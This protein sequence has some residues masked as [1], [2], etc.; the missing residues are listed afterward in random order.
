VVSS[1]EISEM[2]ASRREGKQKEKNNPAQEIVTAKNT[3]K[4]CPECGKDN[5]EDAKFCVGCG[6]SFEEK[7]IEI[8]PEDIKNESDT[9]ICSSCGSEIP[10][11]AKFCVVCGETQSDTKEEPVE[12]ILETPEEPLIKSEKI[13]TPS[14]FEEPIKLII[15]ELV[16]NKE[17]LKFSENIVIEGLSE[18]TELITYENIENIELKDEAGLLTLKIIT[19]NGNIE[20]KGVDPDSGSKFASKAQ[21]MIEEAKPEID[22]ESMDKIKKA[23]ELLDIGAIS[24]EEFE[25]IKKKILEN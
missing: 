4:K 6:K 17:G 22:A 11:N 14:K 19:D 20:I 7:S 9:K 5:K 12:E 1:K 25:N 2:L 24:E 15:K 23:K 21:K 10:K 3:N 13:E 16:L 18:D 8:K